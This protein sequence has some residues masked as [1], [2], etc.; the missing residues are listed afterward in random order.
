M[1]VSRLLQAAGPA[2]HNARMPSLQR[3]DRRIAT[4]K[5]CC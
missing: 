3:L 5:P 1:S 4:D 2:T